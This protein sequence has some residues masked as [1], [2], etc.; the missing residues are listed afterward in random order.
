MKKFFLSIIALFC[1]T[2]GVFSQ[3]T[4]SSRT[5]TMR[6]SST[7]ST[8]NNNIGNVTDIRSGYVGNSRFMGGNMRRSGV[9]NGMGTGMPRSLVGNGSHGT[10]RNQEVKN[11]SIKKGVK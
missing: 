10:S 4:Q 6:S 7:R 1:L 3:T 9:T 2:T 8:V 5:T 11:D